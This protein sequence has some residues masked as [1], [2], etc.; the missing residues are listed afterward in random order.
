MIYYPTA[1]TIQGRA[2]DIKHSD[3]DPTASENLHR[4]TIWVNDN[5][6]SIFVC[7]DDTKDNNVWQT[8]TGNSKDIKHS[9]TDPTVSEN[10]PK[11]TIW[12]NDK[13]G[14]LFVCI[15]DTQ[16]SNVWTPVGS[17]EDNVVHSDNDPT[18]SENLPKGTVWINDNTGQMFVCVDD[19]QDNNVWKPIPLISHNTSDPTASENLPQGT[20]WIN[21]NTG[22]IFICKDATQGNNV[23]QAMP[24]N[25]GNNSNIQRSTD[26]PSSKENLPLGTLWINTNSGKIFVCTDATQDN[27]VWTLIGTDQIR[28]IHDD[29]YPED[30][31]KYPLGT[32]WVNTSWNDLLICTD[33]DDNNYSIWTPVCMGDGFVK[34]GGAN[35]TTDDDFEDG[36]LWINRT[37]A[38]AFVC[39]NG[40]DNTWTPIIGKDKKLNYYNRYPYYHEY[41]D[42]GTFWID[43]TNCGIYISRENE[44]TG[45][46]NNRWGIINGIN[47]LI[48]SSEDPTGDEN[49]PQGSIW[50][51]TKTKYIFI[52]VDNI[53]KKSL[54]KGFAYDKEIAL[55]NIEK[56][57]LFDDG[58][59]KALY[60]FDGTIK[61]ADGSYSIDVWKNSTEADLFP[62]AVFHRGIQSKGDDLQLLVGSYPSDSGVIFTVSFWFKWSGVDKVMPICIGDRY[63]LLIYQGKVGFTTGRESSGNNDPDIWGVEYTFDTKKFRH[64]IAEFHDKDVGSNK[65]W[66]DGDAQDLSQQNPDINYDNSYASTNDNIFVFGRGANGEYRDAGII[67]QMRIFNKALSDKEVNI[68]HY[69]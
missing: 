33:K 52:C 40:S 60:P 1:I 21:D 28:I 37:N 47:N 39:T 24:L 17:V 42:K 8:V 4:G 65:L 11:G 63:G 41:K 44:Y 66:I 20:V 2:K 34:E 48:N 62:K 3:N 7:I 54:W 30:N 31:D 12:I 22:Q 58:S 49:L 45:Y 5:T 18:T 46:A 59:G 27:N 55:S 15:D 13:T 64:I 53:G 38:E 56:V 25:G 50:V 14:K 69:K 51:N 35:P 19:T 6:G 36:T 23:W 61:G 32:M 57:D 29:L 43:N 10:L 68:V 9:D 16:D 26:D 67:D